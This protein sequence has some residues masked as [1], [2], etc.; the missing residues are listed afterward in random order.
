M[1]GFTDGP[2]PDSMMR[3]DIEDAEAYVDLVTSLVIA[4]SVLGFT[5][6]MGL[7]VGVLWCCGKAG[8]TA[9]SSSTSGDYPTV[10]TS[11][12]Q[13]GKLSSV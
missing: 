13:N 1:Q 12:A 8:T 9:Q 3:K 7:M 6:S 2:E 5:S 10:M 4:C 11:Q